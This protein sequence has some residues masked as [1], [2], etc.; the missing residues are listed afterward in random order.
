MRPR[1]LALFVGFTSIS[2]ACG[3]ADAVPASDAT[4]IAPPHALAQAPD[5]YFDHDDVT[6]RY[7]VLGTGTPVVLLHGYTDRVEM[8]GA[9]ADSLAVHRRVIIPDLRGFGRSSAPADSTR[10]GRA[11][12]DDVVALLDRLDAPR[13]H[14]V[15]YSMGALLAAHF[16]LDHPQ[17]VL[18]TTLLAGPFWE[19]SLSS[20]KEMAPY[21]AAIDTDSGLVPFFRAILP[22]WPDSLLQP[23]AEQLLA[24]N[25]RTVLVA[26]ASSFPSLTL[27]WTRVRRSPLPV[28]V[29][30]GTADPLLPHSR[31][32]AERWP[33]A[34]LIEVPDG[35]HANIWLLPRTL[36]ALRDAMGPRAEAH[37]TTDRPGSD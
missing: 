28:T 32:L 15:G 1:I 13:V 11:M 5:D 34:R 9:T 20:A 26:S 35:D 27:D 14:V 31:R 4:D 7:R 33:G 8:W 18:S 16:A 25:D 24:D 22:T 37:A 30:V 21:I 19:D 10:Y 29:V 3:D 36:E 2:T 12:L 23:V 17:R 6:I